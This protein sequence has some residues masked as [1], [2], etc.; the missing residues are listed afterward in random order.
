MQPSFVQEDAEAAGANRSAPNAAGE[1]IGPYGVPVAGQA[2]ARGST[3]ATN[4]ARARAGRG[5]AV[6][7]W[8]A[9]G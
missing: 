8:L 5:L 3:L 4:R 9:A 6:V 1:P 7:D 2:K